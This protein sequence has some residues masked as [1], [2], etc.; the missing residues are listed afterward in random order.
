MFVCYSSDD[1]L[2]E[3]FRRCK[4][5]LK[6]NGVCILKENFSEKKE[7]LDFLDNSVT[8]PKKLYLK[9]I[10]KAGMRVFKEEKQQNFPL[11]LYTVRILM[12]K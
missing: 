4:L 12:F 6:S 11:E 3:F 9:L 2:V 8:R 5:A 1:D 7:E 10:R